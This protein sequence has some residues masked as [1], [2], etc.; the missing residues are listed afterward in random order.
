MG[1]DMTVYKGEEKNWRRCLFFASKTPIPV[2]RFNA[3]QTVDFDT[4]CRVSKLTQI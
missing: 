2:V 1:V 4:V 3:P